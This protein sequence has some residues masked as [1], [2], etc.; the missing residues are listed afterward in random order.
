LP[1][2]VAA[3][4]AL[5]AG[6]AFGPPPPDDGG[7]PPNLSSPSPS[8]STPDSG[9]NSAATASVIAKHLSSPWGLAFLPDGSALVTERK[10]ATIVR[11]GLPQ[12]VSGLT[13]TPIATVAGVSAT[14]DGGLLGIAVS[15]K[16]TTNRTV[17]V[18]YSTAKD[19]R[20]ATIQLPTAVLSAPPSDGAS[21]APSSAPSAAPAPTVTPHPIVTGIPRAVTDNGGWLGFGPDGSLYGSTGD[22]GHPAASADR[23][24]LAGKILRMTVAGKPVGGASLVYATGLH[25]VQGFDWDPTDHLYAVDAATATDGLLA[26]R[27]GA[28]YGWPATGGSASE[29][30]TPPIQMLPAAQAG[31]AGVA[32]VQNILAT[33]C[34]TGERL[35]L[36][37]L[38]ANGAVFGA[39]Q[40]SLAKSFGR[41]RTVVAAPD[42][43]LWIMTSNTDGHGKPSADD[44]QIIQVVVAD[45]GAGKS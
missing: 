17:F 9:D 19:N 26:I 11:V 22:A 6:C 42:G 10:T 32:L 37:R 24:S 36:M 8:P 18:Y 20:I 30:A 13:V 4:C 41:L 44:D 23:K 14:G 5:L 1:V 28:N 31:C 38:T 12:T 21:A 40:A 3:T 27:S 45:A 15:P 33:A 25:D 34:L 29:S 35:W 43:S 7:A 16:V 39:P 2:A